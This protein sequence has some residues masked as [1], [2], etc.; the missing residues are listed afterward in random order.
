MSYE[1]KDSNL[2]RKR[3]ILRCVIDAVISSNYGQEERKDQCRPPS[4]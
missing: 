4:G 2:I 1:A 3:V